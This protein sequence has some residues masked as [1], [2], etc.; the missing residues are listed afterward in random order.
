MNSLAHFTDPKQADIMLRVER[1]VAPPGIAKN[2]T[3][4][5]LRAELE[6]KGKTAE[7]LAAWE[8]EENPVQAVQ[9]ARDV[10]AGKS[11]LKTLTTPA[12]VLKLSGLLKEY[13]YAL[14]DDAK[15]IRNYVINRL[16]EESDNPDPRVRLK[17]VE[18]L[19]KVTEVAAF[20]ERAEVRTQHLTEDDLNRAVMEK[21]QALSRHITPGASEPPE[22]ATV[23]E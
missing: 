21:L 14:I 16:I 11:D 19:G 1:S 6:G 7:L 9:S 3:P 10:F 2:P 5:P 20:T 13:D 17:A 22:D 8:A 18:L 23:V 15:K 12:S 4:L